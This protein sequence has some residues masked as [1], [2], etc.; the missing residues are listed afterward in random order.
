MNKMMLTLA[1]T[2]MI[3]GSAMAQDTMQKQGNT[4]DRSEQ[5]TEMMT[6]RLK[7]TTEQV[8]KVKDIND[9]FAKEVMAVDQERKASKTAGSTTAMKDEKEKVKDLNQKKDE[10]LKGVLTPEQM[11]EWRKMEAQIEER[12]KEK[13]QAKK[14]PATTTT[15]ATPTK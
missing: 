8:P 7:L 15:P 11:G 1:F 14:T 3:G 13:Q 2:A 12:M 5:L 10:E 9:R 6:K 4:G